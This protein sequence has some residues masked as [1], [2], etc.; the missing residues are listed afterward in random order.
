MF[1]FSSLFLL[2]IFINTIINSKKH[3]L[4][5]IFS[6]ILVYSIKLI[7]KNTPQTNRNMYHSLPGIHDIGELED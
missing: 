2:F 1:L 6:N 7:E 4:I 3:T 5:D